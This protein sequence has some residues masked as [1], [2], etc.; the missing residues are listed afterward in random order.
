MKYCSDPEIRKHFYET[1]ISFATSGKYDNR[2]IVLDIL[3]LRDEKAK[4]L[5]YHN[6]AELKLEFKMAQSPKQVKD[7]F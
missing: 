7:L 4:I 6:F 3:H 5:G 1:R 2:S